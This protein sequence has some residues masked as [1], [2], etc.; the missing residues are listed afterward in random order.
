MKL[1]KKCLSHV[2]FV[3]LI[4]LLIHTQRCSSQGNKIDPEIQKLID[5]YV[6]D[7]YIPSAKV[8]GLGLAIIQGDDDIVYSTGYGLA[9]IEK[10][11]PT[12]NSTQF[13]IG[14]VTKV[15]F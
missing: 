13:L 10:G 12:T 5:D 9:N 8:A 1:F 7:V 6:Q 2:K 3:G 14:S 11:I 15:R 4:L